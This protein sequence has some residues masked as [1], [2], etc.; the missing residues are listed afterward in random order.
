MTFAYNYNLKQGAFFNRPGNTWVAST[1]L[2]V[3][4]MNKRY[5][6]IIESVSH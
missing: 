1:G 3:S 6:P 4:L 5:I 2:N